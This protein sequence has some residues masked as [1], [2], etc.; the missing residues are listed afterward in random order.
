MIDSAHLALLDDWT[1]VEAFI[2]VIID[3]IDEVYE[4]TFQS[5]QMHLLEW[6]QRQR[7]EIP[8][9]GGLLLVMLALLD[10]FPQGL[11]IQWQILLT[12]ASKVVHEL[13][14]LLILVRV[15][16][17]K[18]FEDALNQNKTHWQSNN[19]SLMRWHRFGSS[20]MSG[21]ESRKGPTGN[22]LK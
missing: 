3:E 22:L 20:F 19:K 15:Q 18:K 1:L 7:Q 17:L 12:E 4:L 2:Q 14:L 10:M 6:F 16:G 13:V 9:E 21:S 5:Q 11:L 8:V